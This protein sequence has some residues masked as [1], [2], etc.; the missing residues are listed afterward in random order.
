MKLGPNE[1]HDFLQPTGPSK[2]LR[3][4]SHVEMDGTAE[5]GSATSGLDAVAGTDVCVMAQRSSVGQDFPGM[6]GQQLADGS[7]QWFYSSEGGM[8]SEGQ[9]GR[10]L[11]EGWTR[12]DGTRSGEAYAFPK[13]PYDLEVG[14]PPD[15][16]DMDGGMSDSASSSGGST[17]TRLSGFSTASLFSDPASGHHPARRHFGG[18]PRSKICSRRRRRPRA[19][20]SPPPTPTARFACRRAPP[21]ALMGRRRGWAQVW[22]AG[23]R[24]RPPD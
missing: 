10:Q 19:S 15:G 6:V 14:L 23:E 22:L 17:N 8:G 2:S 9:N 1:L 16:T 5:F 18:G 4:R 11:A 7:G 12:Q 24:L 3:A 20:P 13:V 21:P